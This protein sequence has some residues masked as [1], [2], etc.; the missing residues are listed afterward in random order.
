MT[1]GWT[2]RQTNQQSGIFVKS[3]TLR[4]NKKTLFLSLSG[5]NNYFLFVIYTWCSKLVRLTF[6]NTIFDIKEGYAINLIKAYY[7]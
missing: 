2:E 5:S 4:S 7:I 1:D 6:E 3:S